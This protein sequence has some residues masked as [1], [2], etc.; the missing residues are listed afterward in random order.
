M[1]FDGVSQY[2]ACL[3][4]NKRALRS[5][6][7]QHTLTTHR[8]QQ[9]PESHTNESVQ[10]GE[11]HMIAPAFSEALDAAA[12]ADGVRASHDVLLFASSGS[13]ANNAL[14]D[15]ANGVYHHR[16]SCPGAAGS[17]AAPSHPVPR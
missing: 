16:I 2:G 11:F 4:L 14:L 6:R 5:E 9:A 8:Q 7:L 1:L 17:T 10:N 15:V 12:A 13:E 3:L